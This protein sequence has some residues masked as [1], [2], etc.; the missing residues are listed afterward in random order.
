[1]LSEV[2]QTAKDKYCMLSLICENF[3]KR[4]SH[5][6]GD[7]ICGYQKLELE[8]LE[9]DISKWE[10]EVESLIG[11]TNILVYAQSNDIDDGKEP[12]ENGTKKVQERYG[13]LQDAGFRFYL[14]VSYNGS[15]WMSVTKS[16][17]RIGRVMVIGNNM[18]EKPAMY[19]SY[20]DAATIY[21]EYDTEPD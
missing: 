7:Q 9:E 11:E 18:K 4:Q 2:S 19:G 13:M 8:E 14:G 10:T 20:F 17:I 1:M 12:Y 5:Q 3:F 15:S 6:N 16:S 21:E